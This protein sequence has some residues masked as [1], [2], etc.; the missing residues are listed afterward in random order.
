MLLS[1]L[2]IMAEYVAK[3]LN[4]THPDRKHI[5]EVLKEYLFQSD[6]SESDTE[7]MSDT[8]SESDVNDDVMDEQDFDMTVND[9]DTYFKK[10]K[11]EYTVVLDEADEELV[12]CNNYK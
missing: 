9:Q 2:I 1:L 12:K 5:E 7:F 4:S 6:E 3:L 8:E 10:W 11:D